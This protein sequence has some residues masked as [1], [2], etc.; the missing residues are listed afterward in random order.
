MGLHIVVYNVAWAAAYLHTKWH[1]DPAC[2]LARLWPQQ[3]WAEN[4]G[5]HLTQCSLVESI[6]SFILIHPTIGPLYTN[7]TARQTVRTEQTGQ[8]MVL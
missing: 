2:P 7:V 3:I 1:L 6:P 8:I 5:S 4:G